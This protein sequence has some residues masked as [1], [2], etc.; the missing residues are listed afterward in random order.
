MDSSAGAQVL[1]TRKET[2]CEARTHS[3][4][5]NPGEVYLCG[6]VGGGGGF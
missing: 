2:L 4:W 3:L 1:F 6:R 5:I